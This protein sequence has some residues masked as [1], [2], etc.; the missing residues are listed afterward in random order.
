MPMQLLCMYPTSLCKC[1][2]CIRDVQCNTYH[3]AAVVLTPISCI[4]YLPIVPKKHIME[5]VLVEV[6]GRGNLD[7]VIE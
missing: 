3:V 4:N 5:K 7:Y 2:L 6:G 1:K